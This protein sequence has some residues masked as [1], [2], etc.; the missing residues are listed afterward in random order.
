MSCHGER[1]QG[2]PGLA[3]PLKA[4]A[5]VT[6]AAPNEIKETIIKGRVGQNRRHPNIPGGMPGVPMPDEEAEAL[7]K[8]L[9][10][11]LQK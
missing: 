11:D 1:G 4:S 2:I 7:V 5:F 10:G 6:S 9:K 3:P 8:Y